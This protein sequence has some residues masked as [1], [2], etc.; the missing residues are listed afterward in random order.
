MSSSDSIPKYVSIGLSALFASSLPGQLKHKLISFSNYPVV[1][2]LSGI[3]NGNPSLYD[4]ITYYKEH[5]HNDRT[6]IQNTIDCV[7]KLMENVTDKLDMILI[8]TDAQFD[9]MITDQISF[10][11]G[12]YCKKKLPGT[13]FCFW[14]VNGEYIDKLPAEP[15]ENG[16]IMISGY[17]PKIVESL[18]DTVLA[19]SKITKEELIENKRLA[20]EALANEQLIKNQRRQD[21]LNINT[22]QAI[23]DFCEGK[24]SYPLRKELNNI[25]KGIFKDYIWEATYKR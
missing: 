19:A 10:T 23:L 15:S 12:E 16:I 14:N 3:N 25:T 4:Y 18:M 13:L 2:D 6:N 1:Y 8:I 17:N 24:F 9:E 7:A 5:E 22:Y 20:E 21:E 11:A